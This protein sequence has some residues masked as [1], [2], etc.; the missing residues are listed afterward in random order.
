MR[1]LRNVFSLD[2]RKVLCKFLIEETLM[3]AIL[4]NAQ[5][6]WLMYNRRQWKFVSAPSAMI[7][8]LLNSAVYF[9]DPLATLIKG[10]LCCY[11]FFYQLLYVLSNFE[12]VYIASTCNYMNFTW[13]RCFTCVYNVQKRFHT[14]YALIRRC[15]CSPIS[16]AI[17]RSSAT[18]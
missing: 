10:F 18:R 7:N 5:Q 11:E 12:R 4:I 15:T 16:N 14:D 9:K 2:I 13:I 1:N 6:F 3:S 8:V 17:Q